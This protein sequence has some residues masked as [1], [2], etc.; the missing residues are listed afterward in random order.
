MTPT[1]PI[2][3][4]MPVYKENRET[5]VYFKDANGEAMIVEVNSP[6]FDLLNGRFE[7]YKESLTPAEEIAETSVT[8]EPTV[9]PGEE[10]TEGTEV[11]A[12]ESTETAPTAPTEPV[13]PVSEEVE[14]TEQAVNST[15]PQN[16]DTQDTAGTIGVDLAAEGTTSE[17]VTTE[18]APAE[19]VKADAPQI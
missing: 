9:T 7:E 17:T 14:T 8:T 18:V 11:V 6:D 19:E 15:E 1:N 12:P 4:F 2:E 10:K 3:D 16:A 13:A 5:Q